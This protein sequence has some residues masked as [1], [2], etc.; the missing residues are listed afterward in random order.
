MALAALL[1]AMLIAGAGSANAVTRVLEVEPLRRIGLI[2]Y[3]LYLW[4]WPI[5]VMIGT[6]GQTPPRWCGCC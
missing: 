1:S 3:G 5:A 4:H 6:D 2:S